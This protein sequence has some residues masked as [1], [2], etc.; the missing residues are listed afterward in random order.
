[1]D[2]HT[3]TICRQIAD[4][5]LS[6]FDYFVGLALKELNFS[7][8]AWLIDINNDTNITFLHNFHSKHESESTVE[9]K[10]TIVKKRF[11]WIQERGMKFLNMSLQ[12][13]YIASFSIVSIVDFEWVNVCLEIQSSEQNHYFHRSSTDHNQS[14]ALGYWWMK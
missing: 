13:K 10:N 2:K 9:T 8:R 1:M 7:L 3:Q 4:E 12:G 5:L 14:Y 6:V 11:R